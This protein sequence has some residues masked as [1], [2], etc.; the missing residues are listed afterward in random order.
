MTFFTTYQ[1]IKKDCQRDNN[2]CYPKLDASIRC[3]KSVNIN[4]EL[5]LQFSSLNI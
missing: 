3:R 5:G 2:L 4:V 1:K